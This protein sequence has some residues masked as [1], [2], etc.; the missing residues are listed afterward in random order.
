MPNSIV[1]LFATGL[2]GATAANDARTVFKVPYNFGEPIPGFAD[3]Y[4]TQGIAVKVE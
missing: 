2:N 3:Y 1:T 4:F